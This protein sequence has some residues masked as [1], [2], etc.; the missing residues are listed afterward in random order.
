MHFKTAAL[1]AL[2]LV[3]SVSAQTP[4]H[5]YFTNPVGDGQIYKAGSTETFS[6]NLACVPPS[7]FTSATPS[8]VSVVLVNST[9]TNNAFYLMDVATI[10]C[11][12]TSG[13]TQ[14]TVPDK[15][16]S[17][18]LF[19]LK[20]VLSQDVYS[21]KFTISGGKTTPPPTT[22]NPPTSGAK[23]L[24]PVLSSV[25]AAAVAGALYVL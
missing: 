21:S 17:T 10:D 1:A 24:V 5:T 7:T 6:W 2:A 14:W 25:A 16:D 22:T 8:N 19:S 13:N 11:T 4:N 9:N 20:I 3:A 23:S 18:T 15:Y 12:K